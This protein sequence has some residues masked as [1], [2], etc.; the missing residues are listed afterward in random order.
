MVNFYALIW[1]EETY[2]NAEST[3]TK[4]RFP[5]QLIGTSPEWGSGFLTIIYLEEDGKGIL[6]STSNKQ[7]YFR[8]EDSIIEGGEHK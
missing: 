8:S 3:K 7:L 6:L 2:M 4:E 1:Y 5:Y